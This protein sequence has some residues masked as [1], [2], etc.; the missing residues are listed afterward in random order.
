MRDATQPRGELRGIALSWKR[1]LSSGG[2]SAGALVPA[3]ELCHSR[4][5]RR[6][7]CVH[8]ESCTICV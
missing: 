1:W 2:T 5:R 3:L 4:E 6:K 7:A 8:R